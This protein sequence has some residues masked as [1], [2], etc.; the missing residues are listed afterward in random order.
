MH[1][2]FDRGLLSVD[3]NYR[4]LVSPGVIENPTHDYSINK[5]DGKQIHLSPGE[6]YYLAQEN[7][8]WHRENVFK[9]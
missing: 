1:R 5:L 6:Q 4:L 9:G 8:A 3:E 2:A 7:L